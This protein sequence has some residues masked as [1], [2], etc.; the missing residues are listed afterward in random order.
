MAPTAGMIRERVQEVA[1]R[2]AAAR[3]ERQRRR[4][5]VAADFV[6][7]RDAGFLL[8]GAP[9]DQG[10]IWEDV[11]RSTRAVSDILRTLARGDSSVALLR[12]PWGLAYDMLFDLS[13]AA[14]G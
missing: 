12:P 1:S 3:R 11:P 13:C 7:L 4:E 5:L 10:G 2:F 6:Q 9:V 14:P 8:T